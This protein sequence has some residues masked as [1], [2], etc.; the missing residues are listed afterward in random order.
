MNKTK[1]NRIKKK[2][3][4]GGVGSSRTKKEGK[5][6]S[7][8][9]ESLKNE[10]LKKAVTFD[11][12]ENEYH[13][14]ASRDS[15]EMVKFTKKD[16]K[17]QYQAYL[18]EAE[19]VN[20]DIKERNINR[21]KMNE[22]NKDKERKMLKLVDPVKYAKTRQDETRGKQKERKKSNKTIRNRVNPPYIAAAEKRRRAEEFNKHM[23]EFMVQKGDK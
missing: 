7:L 1:K 15:V 18:D 6:E 13:S 16:K 9:N 3:K 14:D 4:G 22:K 10:S 19:D 20:D 2:C 23:E 21:K 8:K 12:A 17:N 11:S 5:N